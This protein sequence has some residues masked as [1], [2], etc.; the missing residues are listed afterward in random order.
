MQGLPSIVCFKQFCLN[1]FGSHNGN[2]TNFK[3]TARPYPCCPRRPPSASSIWRKS[4]RPGWPW[5]WR[6]TQGTGWWRRCPCCPPTGVSSGS[7]CEGPP[8]RC[9]W[10]GQHWPRSCAKDRTR[11]PPREPAGH[12]LVAKSDTAL[13]DLNG[14]LIGYSKGCT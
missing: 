3:R 2:L 13:T 14:H 4:P 10:T 12:R 11:Q 1:S 6:C 8:G 5:Q 7:V 9:R